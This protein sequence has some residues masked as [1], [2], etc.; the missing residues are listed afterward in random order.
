MLRKTFIVI[1]I[2]ATARFLLGT[3]SSTIINA[4][5]LQK[6]RIQDL[7]R[8][9]D[10]IFM[11][12]ILTLKNDLSFTIPSNSFVGNVVIGNVGLASVLIGQSDIPPG[13]EEKQVTISTSISSL[14]DKI[15]EVAAQVAVNPNALLSL[16]RLRGDFFSNGLKIPVE[17]K[18]I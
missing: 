9:G 13:M 18:L 2:V 15:P 4:V 3:A 1:G 6:W 11:D 10:T 14:I 8:S 17:L 16:L 12:V 5:K 7:T